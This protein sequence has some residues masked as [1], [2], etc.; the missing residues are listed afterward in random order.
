[1]KWMPRTKQANNYARDVIHGN[2]FAI[3][4]SNVNG[5]QLPQYAPVT[6]PVVAYPAKVEASLGASFG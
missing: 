2:T 4:C 1:M 5:F 6:H 3:F